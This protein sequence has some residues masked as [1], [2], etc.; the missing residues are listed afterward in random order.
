MIGVSLRS[1]APQHCFM[2]VIDAT[3]TETVLDVLER[4]VSPKI[5][6]ETNCN[7]TYSSCA[8]EPT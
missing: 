3:T 7:P 5:T 4:R 2:D 1:D 8:R 6:L